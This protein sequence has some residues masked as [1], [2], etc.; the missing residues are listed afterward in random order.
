MYIYAQ[1]AEG[2]GCAG[3]ERRFHLLLGIQ[4]QVYRQNGEGGPGGGRTAPERGAAD[5]TL[6]DDVSEKE[7]QQRTGHPQH[8]EPGSCR[9]T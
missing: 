1:V 8:A 3:G 2:V 7:G 6:P 9:D 4:V 5:T